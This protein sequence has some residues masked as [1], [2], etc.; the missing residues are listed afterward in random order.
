MYKVQKHKSMESR[1][2]TFFELC[3]C[4][5]AHYAFYR[6]DINSSS[7]FS[8]SAEIL[9]FHVCLDSILIFLLVLKHLILVSLSAFRAWGTASYSC[10]TFL[11]PPILFNLPCQSNNWDYS[12]LMNYLKKNQDYKITVILVYLLLH[13]FIYLLSSV[14]PQ[15]LSCELFPMNNEY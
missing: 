10:F 9:I 1:F 6:R 7:Q 13:N 8:Q 4:L 2:T 11:S 3:C 5:L 14:L 12:F 15:T